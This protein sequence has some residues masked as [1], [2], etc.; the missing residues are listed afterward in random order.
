MSQPDLNARNKAAWEKLY[1][2][3]S[4]SVWG[5]TPVGFLAHHLPTPGQL[6]AGDV[7]DAAAGEGRNLP[8]L[9]A[10]GRTVVACDSSPA[11][12]AKIPAA[13]RARVETLACDLAHVP[14]GA[15]KFALILLS[16]VV[17]T[18]PD[19][20]AVLLEM[21]R[22]LAP[23][24]VL[25]VNIPG[26]DDGV[27]G[28]EMEAAGDRGWLYRGRYYYKFHSREEAE[29]LLR[30]AGL[31]VLSCEPCAW[32]EEPHPEFR[33]STHTHRSFVLLARRPVISP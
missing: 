30:A 5:R 13:I 12:L 8:P 31:Q 11:A 21:R 15:G 17:E 26:D 2:A 29:S 24:G 9:L 27:A 33:D 3:T 20:V 25:L 22:L 28:V 10:L 1:A 18:L 7:L 6:P 19:A 16:D 14:I 32:E 4:D 23:D